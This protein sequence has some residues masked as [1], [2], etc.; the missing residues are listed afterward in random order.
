MTVRERVAKLGALLARV[1]ERAQAPRV[2]NGHAGHAAP[3]EQT[4]VA[5]AAA[6]ISPESEVS[7]ADVDALM[8]SPTPAP[9]PVVQAA[10]VAVTEVD[11]PFSPPPAEVEI[12][13]EVELDD[14][15]A[16]PETPE[17]PSAQPS[18]AV[19]PE[20]L[21]SRERMVAAVPAA[22][23]PTALPGTLITPRQEEA[24][25]ASSLQTGE[26][27]AASAVRETSG[28]DDEESL[29]ADT[30]V[31]PEVALRAPDVPDVMAKTS[32]TIVEPPASSRR[33]IALEPKLEELAFGEGAPS[34]EPHA[35]PPE[36]GRQVAALPVELDFE[37]EF[38]GVRPKDA[39]P[40]S[41]PVE[42][43]TDRKSQAPQAVQVDASA[44]EVTAARHA[45][46]PSAVFDGEAPV[47]KPATFGELLD[48]SLSL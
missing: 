34:E 22:S 28:L 41:S 39:E 5:E 46:G 42:K 6:E 2:R 19:E 23:A 4:D 45:S 1:S 12:L 18:A 9:P 11:E 7:A 25:R 14:E 15:E 13:S 29:D 38:T 44:P 10:P 27:L 36:S 43:R 20:E 48:A 47:F 8:A 21:P 33:P 32:E 37:T 40:A 35:P 24:D 16:A 30:E 3:I 31:P 17:T 26:R